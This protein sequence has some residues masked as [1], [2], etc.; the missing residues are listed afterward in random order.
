MG[1]VRKVRH[2]WE[3]IAKARIEAGISKN[4][5]AR[6]LNMQER[7]YRR[8]E[9]EPG[10][11]PPLQHLETFCTITDADLREAIEIVYGVTIPGLSTSPLD[12]LAP[13]A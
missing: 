8:W 3:W 2:R 13:V 6:R 10:V 1:T 9:R 12:L 11:Q 7:A 5:M 4:G